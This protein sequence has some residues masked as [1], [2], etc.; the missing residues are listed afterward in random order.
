MPL[1]IRSQSNWIQADRRK[2][3][4][5]DRFE[6]IFAKRPPDAIDLAGGNHRGGRF[7]IKSGPGAWLALAIGA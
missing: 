1:M 5:P 2:G 6:R 3:Q 4:F 7:K